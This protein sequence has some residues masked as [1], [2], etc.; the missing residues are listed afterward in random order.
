[1]DDAYMGREPQ[2]NSQQYME[3]YERYLEIEHEESMQREQQPPEHEPQL[4][5]TKPP[6]Q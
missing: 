5:T 1:M 2:M 6:Q 3:G 4:F